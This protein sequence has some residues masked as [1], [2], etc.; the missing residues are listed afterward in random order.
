LL[1]A[2]AV[3]EQ[4]A[5]IGDHDYRGVDRNQSADRAAY[6]RDG[7]GAILGIVNVDESD[8]LQEPAYDVDHRGVVVDHEHRY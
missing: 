3:A 2:E 6:S 4:T 7:R 1:V 5:R 8:L